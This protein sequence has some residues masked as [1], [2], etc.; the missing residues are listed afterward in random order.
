MIQHRK[1]NRML[2][3]RRADGEMVCS[4]EEISKKLN[5][6]YGRLLEEPNMDKSQTIREIANNILTILNQDH[7]TMLLK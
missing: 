6:F 3:L 5:T 2:S 7:N 4:Q 1:T